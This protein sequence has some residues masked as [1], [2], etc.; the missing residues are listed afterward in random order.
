MVNAVTQ[1]LPYVVDRAAIQRMLEECKGSID[2]AV[3][4]LLD[5]EERGSVSSAQTSSSIERDP[6][7]DDDDLYAPNKR[8]THHRPRPSRDLAIRLKLSSPTKLNQSTPDTTATAAAVPTTPSAQYPKT[9]HK[10]Q[11]KQHDHEDS[12]PKRTT[13]RDRK[14]TKKAAQKAAAKERKKGGDGGK[15]GGGGGG[16]VLVGEGKE[17]AAIVGIKVLY[18]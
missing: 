10:T 12:K 5:A 4:K 1:S 8:K 17:N 7:S 2:N 15:N 13:A 14:E 16:G 11:H 3:S 18:I 6:D 9:G